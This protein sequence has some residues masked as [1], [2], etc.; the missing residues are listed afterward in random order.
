[1]NLFRLKDSNST[2][3]K[4]NGRV[5]L[6]VGLV[7]ACFALSH[8]ALA[9]LPPPPPDGGYPGN[10]TAEGDF[11]L[12]NLTT[13]VNNTALGH[14]ALFT[15]STGFQNTATGAGALQLN[16]TGSCNI[17]IGNN[18]VAGE[19]NT[20]RIGTVGGERGCGQRA[21]FIAGI[22]GAPI[23]GPT[24]HISGTGQLGIGPPSSVRFKQNIKPMDKASDAILALKPVT[25]RYKKEL[26]PE[27]APQFGLLAEDVEKVNPDLVARDA[28]GKVYTVRYEAVNAMLLNEFLK[29]H[30]TVQEQK[31]TIAQLKSTVEKQEAT[32]AQHQ[33]E[34]EALTAG[35]QK[36][37]AQVEMSKPAPRVVDSN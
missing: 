25:F 5:L 35:L 4:S 37:S 10:N 15:N 14:A 11:A 33:K 28:E 27:G 24:V 34:I 2:N 1:M 7:L 18:G 36:V 3:P 19:S 32:N 17:D 6:L 16:T 21:T 29:E 12:Q 20:I 13:G 22:I 30:I 8:R 9:Q 26:D 23:A 31:A